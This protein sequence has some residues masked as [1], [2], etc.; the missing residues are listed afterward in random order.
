MGVR[1]GIWAATT[2]AMMAATAASAAPS[3]PAATA[4]TPRAVVDRVAR[5]IEDD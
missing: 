4:Q 3:A 5:L 1:F 2:A